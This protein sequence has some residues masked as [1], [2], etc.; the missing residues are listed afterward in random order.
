MITPIAPPTNKASGKLFTGL[1]IPEA[2]NNAGS[3]TPTPVIKAPPIS[4]NPTNGPSNTLA[5]RNP[6]AN[7]AAAA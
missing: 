6:A 4:S 3:P 5:I 7:P 2:K 1:S